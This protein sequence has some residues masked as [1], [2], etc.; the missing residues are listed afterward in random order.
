MRVQRGSTRTL[1][2]AAAAALLAGATAADDL[3]TDPTALACADKVYVQGR[4]AG[5]SNGE[6]GASV[7]R[8]ASGRYH[9]HTITS[10]IAGGAVDIRL[11]PDAV[12]I[13]H[14]HPLRTQPSP[15]SIDAALARRLGIPVYTLQPEGV[16]RVDP[17]GRVTQEA[18]REWRRSKFTVT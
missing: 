7:Y 2:I 18:G 3:T 14:T 16:F 12:A 11:H 4:L 5:F 8:D 6:A 15:S 10:S 17:T 9:C 1:T 13:L